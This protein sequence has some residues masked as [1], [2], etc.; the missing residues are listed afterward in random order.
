MG[1]QQ[2]NTSK[3]LKGVSSQTLITIVL[4]VIEIVTFSIMS[5]LLSQEDFGYYAAILAVVVIFECLSTSGIGSSIIQK[6]DA[7]DRFINVAFTCS[8][9]LGVAVMLIMMVTAKSIARLVA[10]ENMFYP[11]LLMAITLPLHCLTSINTSQM[12]KRLEFIRVGSINLISMVITSFLSVTLAYYD[13]GYYAI[14]AKAVAGAVITC[15]L[16]FLLVKRRYKLVF[17]KKD[18]KAIFSFSGWLTISA[19]FRDLA[20][21]L[22]RLLMSNLLSVSALGAYNRPKEFIIQISTR[23]NGIFDSALFPVLSGIQDDYE[24]VRSAYGR[25]LYYM[26]MFSL[27]LACGFI[28][29]SELIICVFFGEEWMSVQ[30]TFII[31]S[32]SLIFN[33]DGR[34]ADCFFRSLGWTKQQ[35]FFRVFEVVISIIGILVSYRWGVNGIA[36]SVLL[37]SIIVIFFKNLYIAIRIEFSIKDSF[38]SIIRSWKFGIIFI[39]LMLVA[40]I[41]LSSSLWTNILVAIIFAVL[42]IVI[43]IQFPSIVGKQ[44]K[45]DAYVQVKKLLNRFKNKFSR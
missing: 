3:V 39:P 16:S 22:D 18:F 17:N 42:T 33:I 13:F 27:L 4:G 19:F 36:T 9:V 37:V 32:L 11:L 40:K 7:S 23:L 45:E 30:S 44:Y 41:I 8:L 29:N 6:K 28:F 12:Y 21:Q 2:S 26:N 14:I 15:I 43:F 20:N 5:R 31:I 35:F 24:R 38:M 25:S 34:L 1:K 10:D